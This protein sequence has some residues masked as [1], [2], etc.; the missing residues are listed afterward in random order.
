MAWTPAKNKGAVN[1][2]G[3]AV[4]KIKEVNDDGSDLSTPG[5]IYDI[6]YI[7]ESGFKD[8]TSNEIKKDEA[9]DTIRKI[10]TDRE[11][12][13][14]GVLMQSDKSTLDLAK[15]VRGKFYALLKQNGLK[16]GKQQEVF[17]GVGEIDPNFDV[18]YPGGETPFRFV[19]SK[20]NSTLTIAAASLT[21]TL[22]NAFS[23]ATVTIAKDDYYTIVETAV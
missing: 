4:I 13:I 16:D 22:W 15:E 2:K 1:S 23:S 19:A 3:G 9:G 10:D 18:K 5:T 17:F 21:A 11:V 7:K 6:G 8:V 12:I 14:E 20:V